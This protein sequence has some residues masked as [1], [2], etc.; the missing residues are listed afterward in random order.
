MVLTSRNDKLINVIGIKAKRFKAA[1]DSDYTEI[2]I[3]T[4]F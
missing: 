4:V 3:S 2:V 1:L